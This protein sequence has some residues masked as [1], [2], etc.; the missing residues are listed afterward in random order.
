MP[1]QTG[2]EFGGTFHEITGKWTNRI[3]RLTGTLSGNRNEEVGKYK[4]YIFRKYF[5]I[6]CIAYI[7]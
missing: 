4:I 2:A 7:Y 3:R 6:L 5:I 1:A